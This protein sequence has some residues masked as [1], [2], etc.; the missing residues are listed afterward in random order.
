MSNELTLNTGNF[1]E[2]AKAMGIAESVKEGSKQST[3][4]R[5]RIWH[6]PVMGEVEVKGKKKKMEVVEAGSYRLEIGDGKFAYAQKV[7]FRIFMQRFMYK[8]YLADVKQFQKTL[9]G[10]SL[11]VDLKDNVGGFNCG[12]PSGYIED[13]KALPKEMQDLIR[14][15]KR[16]RVLFGEVE[17]VDPVDDNG[18]PIDVST[19][20]VIWEVDNKDAF[21]TTGD[22]LA[23]ITKQRVLPLQRTLEMT[24]ENHDLP[25]GSSFATPNIEIGK[26]DVAIGEQDQETFEAFAEWVNNY[27]DYIVNEWNEKHKDTVT[28]DEA[29]LV[30]DFIDME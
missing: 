29:D 12:K 25:N 5:F 7:N 24:T 11:N 13:F 3:L 30:E 22:V 19:T 26:A 23:R 20:P 28:T 10:D 6:S 4:A 9:M 1:A 15:I 17:L 27:N 16:V 18:E 14:S 2:M 8:R 21:K